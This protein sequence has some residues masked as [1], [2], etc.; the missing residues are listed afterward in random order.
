MYIVFQ[1]KM[2]FG[3][4]ARHLI[5]P[6]GDCPETEHGKYF[7]LNIYFMYFIILVAMN[8]IIYFFSL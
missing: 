2:N 5:L 1:I 6:Y 7:T 4:I 8:E 3:N